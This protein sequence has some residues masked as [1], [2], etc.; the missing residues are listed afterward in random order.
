M[1]RRAFIR[2][3][4]SIAALAALQAATGATAAAELDGG[5]RRSAS[6]VDQKPL[7]FDPTSVPGLSEKFLASHYNN[8][9]GGA[10][11]RLNAINQQLANLDYLSAASFSINGLKREQLMATNAVILHEIYFSGLGGGG[12]PGGALASALERD[13]GSVGKWRAEFSAMGKALG[14]GSGW[15]LLSYSPRLRRMDNFWANDHTMTVVD[16]IPLLALDM[17]EHSYHMDYGSNAG[18]YVDASMKVIKWDYAQSAFD[19]MSK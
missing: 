14:G 18:T 8:N 5:G 7:P 13:F 1:E 11:R 6:T 3:G 12:D 9:Y 2:A 17:Y 16:G 19:Q 4:T 15:I 10:V